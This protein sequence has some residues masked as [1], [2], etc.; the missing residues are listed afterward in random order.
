MYIKQILAMIFINIISIPKSTSSKEETPSSMYAELVSTSSFCTEAASS[1][2]SSTTVQRGSKRITIIEPVDN[3]QT[4]EEKKNRKL[5]YEI[6]KRH[7]LNLH[8]LNDI[9]LTEQ[10]PSNYRNYVDTVHFSLHNITPEIIENIMLAIEEKKVNLRKIDFKLYNLI[11]ALQRIQINSI[12]DFDKKKKIGNAQNIA[13]TK[14][15]EIER[16]CRNMHHLMMRQDINSQLLFE[17]RRNVWQTLIGIKLSE[18]MQ[19]FKISIVKNMKL[20]DIMLILNRKDDR[21]LYSAQLFLAKMKIIENISEVQ[22]AELI[23]HIDQNIDDYTN[24]FVPITAGLIG[25]LDM[26]KLLSILQLPVYQDEEL[27]QEFLK[28]QHCFKLSQILERTPNFIPIMDKIF[29]LP[30]EQIK[31]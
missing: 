19:E 9:K 28:S 8:R 30:K 24:I 22:F 7:S 11:L 15:D 10:P 14:K 1:S 21:H 20:Q 17:I 31:I 16:Y 23:E 13:D 2:S 6:F 18:D 12:F 27:K 4:S 5:L 26:L 29:N 25:Q 3:F